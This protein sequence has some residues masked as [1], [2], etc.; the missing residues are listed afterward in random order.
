[1]ICDSLA[2]RARYPLGSAFRLALDFLEQ[3]TPATPD[4]TYEL[5]GRKVYAMVQSYDTAPDAVESLE[6]HRQYADIQ[7][8]I[9]GNEILVWAHDTGK[10]PYASDYDVDRDAGFLTAPADDLARLDMKPGI[11]AVFFPGDAHRGKVEPLSGPNRV[12]KV[13][14]KV[15]VGLL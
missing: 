7:Y 10:I 9:S 12:K 15:A 2:N 4:G 3:V 1:M 14:V 13:C 11:F 6:V 5:D 8:T